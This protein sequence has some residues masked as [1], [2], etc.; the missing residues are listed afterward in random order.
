MENDYELFLTNNVVVNIK[1]SSEFVCFVNLMRQLGLIKINYMESI[2]DRYGFDEGF[3]FDGSTRYCQPSDV[4]FEYQMGKGF[5]FFNKQQY[6]S[7]DE[8][9][10][11]S[12]DDIIMA[13]TDGIVVD[14]V[15]LEKPN[16]REIYAYMR[17]NTDEKVKDYFDV[18]EYDE[19]VKKIENYEPI[20]GFYDLRDFEIPE[21][22]FQELWKLQLYLKNYQENKD[23]H[24]LAFPELW[25]LLK[26]TATE[27]Q[28][29][30]LSYPQK[31]K[32]NLEEEIER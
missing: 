9:K 28:T 11:C 6:L 21:K 16:K 20:Y 13:T 22:D 15:I 27:Y 24:S 7:N 23:K 8:I 4:C 25:H 17:F 5:T 12:L 18:L 29:K 30:L 2:Y 10:I 31:V 14:N 3:C 19:M 26:K 1:D 32:D